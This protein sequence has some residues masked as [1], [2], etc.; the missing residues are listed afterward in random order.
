[1]APKD[2]KHVQT[3][4]DLAL[5]LLSMKD[6]KAYLSRKLQSIDEKHETAKTW[7][8]ENEKSIV[9]GYNAMVQALKTA[10]TSKDATG[11]IDF[12]NKNS[13]SSNNIVGLVLDIP[14]PSGKRFYDV[15][16]NT[17]FNTDTKNANGLKALVESISLGVP[18]EAL[19][20][21]DQNADSDIDEAK[22]LHAS[23]ADQK[24]GWWQRVSGGNKKEILKEFKDV[25]SDLL[26]LEM[27]PSHAQAMVKSFFDYVEAATLEEH[28]QNYSQD[29]DPEI[30]HLMMQFQNAEYQVNL[31]QQN[32]NETL[33][34][35]TEQI[36][37]L[38][39]SYNSLCEYV[40]SLSNPTDNSAAELEAIIDNCPDFE[41]INNWRLE[42]N[43]PTN[44]P[45]AMFETITDQSSPVF[46][47][48]LN[49]L[50]HKTQ[51]QTTDSSF[52]AYMIFKRALSTIVTHGK[53]KGIV[54][55]VMAPMLESFSKSEE[56]I[57]FQQ[58]FSIT[59]PLRKLYES[60][61]ADGDKNLALK[62]LLELANPDFNSEALNGALE[63]LTNLENSNFENTIKSFAQFESRADDQFF[64]KVYAISKTLKPDLDIVQTALDHPEKPASAAFFIGAHKSGLNTKRHSVEN[65]A[66]VVK[67]ALTFES[68]LPHLTSYYGFAKGEFTLNKDHENEQTDRIKDSLYETLDG[69]RLIDIALNDQNPD[70]L[71]GVLS[72][73]NTPVARSN[74]LRE[75]AENT[76]NDT[77]KNK[78]LKVADALDGTFLEF[79]DNNVINTEKLANLYYHNTVLSFLSD[80]SLAPIP[81]EI[82]PYDARDV[83]LSLLERDN[84][85]LIGN[86][87]LNPT[88]ISYL[89]LSQNRSGEDHLTLLL[90]GQKVTVD[91]DH[92][93]A[94]DAL[95]SIESV[96]TSLV[97]F[98]GHFVDT[99]SAGYVFFD[100]NI[101]NIMYEDTCVL[102]AKYDSNDKANI[103]KA[104]LN[105]GNFEQVGDHLI[106]NQS[107]DLLEYNEDTQEITVVS[108]NAVYKEG[109]AIKMLEQSLGSITC[110][111]ITA[112]KK[113]AERLMRNLEQKG[114][115]KVAN[116]VINPDR[117]SALSSR[118]DVLTL[119]LSKVDIAINTSGTENAL[120][121][122]QQ[123]MK[124]TRLGDQCFNATRTQNMWLSSDKQ[125]LHIVID[126]R[127]FQA[128]IT[129][130]G[131][132]KELSQQ[133]SSLMITGTEYFDPNQV[134]YLFTTDKDAAS[135]YPKIKTSFSSKSTEITTTDVNALVNAV[136]DTQIK[137]NLGTKASF[138]SN[139]HTRS[140]SLSGQTINIKAVK[141]TKESRNLSEEDII[142]GEDHKTKEPQYSEMALKLAVRS[143]NLDLIKHLQGANKTKSAS[144]KALL[145]TFNQTAKNEKYPAIQRAKQKH[146]N[147]STKN[148]N[149]K[150][151][152]F[153]F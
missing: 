46:F 112:E 31:A 113:L 11:I 85:V 98:G 7:I 70:V 99:S 110:P 72:F 125:D 63:I 97:E 151:S 106:N 129:E 55:R 73:L 102:S 32:F 128:P 38:T 13:T 147:H 49:V 144:E 86:E 35:F 145:D 93:S 56:P 139:F 34:A 22:K 108:G 39:I 92:M 6:K 40:E 4:E 107:I 123:A 67:N 89:A 65:I 48:Q 23:E 115:T 124:L 30:D 95:T 14:H 140:T 133:N 148:G 150:N 146:Y 61:L 21:I 2:P 53:S 8:G 75:V 26:D 20:F 24:T 9:I 111:R 152:K 15:M 101:L 36:V 59:K 134:A 17:L 33:T 51:L 1:M 88:K 122:L 87:I 117:L 69:E 28:T 138:V 64:N 100:D 60:N 103:A 114:H 45:N 149:F 118:D 44:L 42:S 131:K 66:E 137:K 43:P 37:D 12:I 127:K 16:E 5:E 153:K 83:F 74:F 104:F 82:S 3:S 80:G 25:K 57:H 27:H 143:E 29:K 94:E 58:T 71:A 105:T 84:F 47:D 79:K 120:D 126:G 10:Q 50:N 142:F 77:T 41:K 132:L 119:N 141:D 90:D 19:S 52:N 121:K 96:N 78:Y 54:E 81:H 136:V 109:H 68:W 91:L 135:Q 116:T 18:P 130:P 62:T 76:T